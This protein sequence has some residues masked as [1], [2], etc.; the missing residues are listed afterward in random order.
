M[1]AFLQ[2]ELNSASVDL[3]GVTGTVFH[4]LLC[5]VS[6]KQP[7]HYG[8]ELEHVANFL[9]PCRHTAP[10]RRVQHPVSSISM[11]WQHWSVEWTPCPA[12]RP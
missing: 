1:L 9:G 11:E 12:Q 2:D 7:R 5:E 10:F 6:V 4:L 3:A 8:S